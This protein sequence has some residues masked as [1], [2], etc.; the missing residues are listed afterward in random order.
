MPRDGNGTYIRSDGVRVG[1]TVFAQQDA[2]GVPIDTTFMDTES[3][4]MA[5]A[6]T[7]SISKDGQ[8]VATANLPMGGQK[9]TDVADPTADDQYVTLNYAK[10][11]ILFQHVGLIQMWSGTI[12]NIP[13]KYSLCD[14]TGGTPDLRDNFILSV[15]AAEEPGT[16][17][18][19]ADGSTI[20][21][22][23]DSAGT[24]VGTVDGHTL[25]I[26]QMP[27][28]THGTNIDSATQS[29]GSGDLG[30]DV[31]P[32]AEVITKSTGGGGSHNHGFTGGAMATHSHNST[33][34]FPTFFKLAFIMFTG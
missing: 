20:A 32:G 27:A 30:G 23:S 5:N 18:G 14:G 21:T 9:H 6:L 33:N 24:S 34:K 26:A 28:H 13:A 29:A 19:E 22:S 12:A 31:D 10:N 1:P 11:N 4:D 17:G 3:Q 16:T 2:S 25:T 15:G 8:T 7:Q